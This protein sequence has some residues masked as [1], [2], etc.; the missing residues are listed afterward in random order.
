MITGE[1][2]VL[3]KTLTHMKRGRL[4]MFLELIKGAPDHD[5]TWQPKS[6]F[7]D[8]DGTI[9]DVWVDY[10]KRIGILP[11]YYYVTIES[12]EEE[13]NRVNGEICNNQFPL[14]QVNH[15]LISVLKNLEI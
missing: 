14:M 5:A 2:Q 8:I 6:D 1:E 4:H 15:G 10:I 12:I 7:V 3:D 9:T 11:K 13:D